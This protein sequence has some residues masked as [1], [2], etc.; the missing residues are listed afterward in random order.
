MIHFTRKTIHKSSNDLIRYYFIQEM[1][2]FL[3][4]KGFSILHKCPFLEPESELLGTE[5]NVSFV[6]QALSHSI[7]VQL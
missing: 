5:W 3:Q 6:V 7:E 1:H 2:D 4:L